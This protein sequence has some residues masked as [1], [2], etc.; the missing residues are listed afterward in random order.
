MEL[1]VADNAFVFFTGGSLRSAPTGSRVQ[2][3]VNQCQC[4]VP[5]PPAAA[6]LEIVLTWE[7]DTFSSTN[8]VLLNQNSEG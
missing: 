4:G 8:W 2:T 5:G 6:P 3:P 1:A 7:L